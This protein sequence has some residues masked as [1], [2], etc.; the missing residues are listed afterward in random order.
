VGIW[1]WIILL[2]W[3]AAL[4]T[5]AQYTLFRK[6]RGPEDYDWVYIAGGA[7][8]GGFTAHIW[9]SGL[10][11]VVDGLNVVQALAGGVVGGIAVELVYRVFMRKA[12]VA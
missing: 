5:V 12:K 2:A 1:A 4:A 8:L 10:G 9:Y 3:S 6:D 7:L 11:P